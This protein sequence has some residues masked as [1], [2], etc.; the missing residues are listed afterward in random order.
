[1]G[2]RTYTKLTA[3]VKRWPLELFATEKQLG[4]HVKKTVLQAYGSGGK[5][6]AA[7]EVK[8]ER[9]YESCNRLVNNVHK[10]KFVRQY[11]DF[12]SSGIEKKIPADH[13]LNIDELVELE[14]HDTNSRQLMTKIKN[15]FSFK[16]PTEKE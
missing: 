14:T 11:P 16:K 5:V 3:L 15:S 4:D 6:S 10:T 9:F 8:L 13:R 2:S 7:D 12:T 1:M